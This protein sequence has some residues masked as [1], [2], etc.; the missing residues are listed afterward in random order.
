[1]K[2]LKPAFLILC[3][4]AVITTRQLHAQSFFGMKTGYVLSRFAATRGNEALSRAPHQSVALA[5]VF[6]GQLR[7]SC[8]GVSIEPGYI[9]KGANFK[10]SINYRLNYLNVP[11]LLHFKPLKYLDFHAGPEIAFL[12]RATGVH[13]D[14]QEKQTS[15][16]NKRWDLSGVVGVNVALTY[17]MDLG[18]RYNNSFFKVTQYD[19]NIGYSDI[20][21]QYLQVYIL[22]KV[23]N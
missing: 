8:M 15:L 12:M 22:L 14:Y 1:M 16:Y 23:V 5:M 21:N 4:V 6:H 13:S 11:I 3:L 20:K 7:T 17:Y 9:Q 10:D 2:L 18:F 19:P